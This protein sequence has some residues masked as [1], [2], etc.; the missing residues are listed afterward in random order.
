MPTT[1]AISN[2]AGEI[3]FFGSSDAECV[4]WYEE[5]GRSGD[6]LVDTGELMSKVAGE[7]AR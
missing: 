1:H 7:V 4:R 2:H 5:N 3:V 6:Y